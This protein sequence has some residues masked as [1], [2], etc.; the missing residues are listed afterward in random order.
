M[1]PCCSHSFSRLYFLLSGFDIF[2]FYDADDS[3]LR[4]KFRCA[5]EQGAPARRREGAMSYPFTPTKPIPGTY[6]QT[7]AEPTANGTTF[8]S[9]AGSSGLK[10][11][12]SAASLPQ[13]T[14]Q[15]MA[16]SAA[17]NAKTETMTPRER[18]ARTIDE[19]L[20][21]EARFPDLDSYLSRTLP[22]FHSEFWFLSS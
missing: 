14:R 17:D 16:S 18:A 5:R 8:Q 9:S 19:V 10:R 12:A 3:R 11:T 15:K 7:P 1:R 13:T 4:S 20:L 21:Q 2:L 6:V 22:S